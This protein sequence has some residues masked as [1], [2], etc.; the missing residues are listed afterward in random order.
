MPKIQIILLF[1]FIDVNNIQKIIIFSMKII[2]TYYVTFMHYH[3][4][5]SQSSIDELLLV[6]EYVYNF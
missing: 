2:Y 6:Y 3:Y 4:M 1:S 5:V